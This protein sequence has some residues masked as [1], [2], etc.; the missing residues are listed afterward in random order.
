MNRQI[1]NAGLLLLLL[2][3]GAG[4]MLA[5]EASL[6]Q[7]EV[8]DGWILLFDGESTFGLTQAGQL[9]WRTSN[10]VLSTD[11]SGTGYIRTNSPFADFVLKMDV[12]LA[13][14]AA[15]AA[16]YIRTARDGSP[17]DNGYQIRIGDGNPAWPAGS[18]VSRFKATAV[19]PQG[20][21]WHSFEIDADGDH[22]VVLL[23]QKT[24]AEGNDSTVRAGY[25]GFKVS[26]ASLEIRD[27]KLK[28]INNAALFNGSDLAGWKTVTPG[29][30]ADKQG[31]LKKLIPFAAGG[32]TNNKGPLWSVQSGTI[33]GE[34]GPGQL[35]TVAT[36]D[37]F[38]LQF[39]VP[40]SVRKQQGHHSV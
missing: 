25:I 20:G 21:Q 12:R 18:V 14:P 5:K 16:L 30:D 13:N 36:Y 6:T 1:N 26:G 31:R 33:H 28:P 39:G 40:P 7:A 4:P 37:D 29:P 32:K 23:D 34:K 38:V 27:L 10:G 11:G 9:A 19:H 3:L 8:K 15:D 2:V 17:T 24:V 22:I 35:E